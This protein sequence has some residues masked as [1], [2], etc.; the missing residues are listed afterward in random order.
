MIDIKE[1]TS[2]FFSP[3]IVIVVTALAAQLIG[4]YHA[5][6]L[7]LGGYFY[8][9]WV[10]VRILLPVAVLI[11]LRVPLSR[12]GLGLPQF[13]RL[14]RNLVL[15][16]VV[17]LIAAFA[18]IYF[19]K[20]YFTHYSASFAGPG[21]SSLDRFL[22]FMIF[23]SSTLTGWEFIHRGFLL[24]GLYYVLGERDNVPPETAARIAIA[25]VWVFEVVFHF[26]KPELEALGL[27]V[28]S[29]LLSWLALRLR[30]IWVPFLLHFLVELLFI[31]TLIMQ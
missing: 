31:T 8:L 5:R 7:V 13:D 4:S 21:G 19:L 15:A 11:A 25:V 17:I 12:I 23:T 22:N 24:M 18:G 20:G 2:S 10:I 28:G 3:F 9:L 6:S 30:S 16:A 29:P 1:K 27:L 26:I 14:T